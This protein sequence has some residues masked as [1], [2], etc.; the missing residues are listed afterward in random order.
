MRH[1]L[2]IGAGSIGERHIRCFQK[3]GRANVSVCEI[4][5]AL[6]SRIA[7]D[8]D[9]Q[10]TYDDLARALSAKPDGVVIAIP[11]DL[12]IPIALQ[13]AEAGCHLLIEKPLSTGLTGV[14][15]LAQRMRDQ[16]LV[17]QVG[18]ILR[19]YPLAAKVK[20]GIDQ[21]QWGKPLQLT[22]VSGQNFPTCRPAYREIYYAHHEKG[23]G[24]IQDGLTHFLDTAHWWLGPIDRLTGDMGHLSL[25]GVEVEDTV[26]VLARHGNVM[27]LY[28]FNQHQHPNETTFTLVCENATVRLDFCANRLCVMTQPDGDWVVES[29]DTFQRDDA[30]INQADAFLDAIDGHSTISCTLDEAW[31]TL[32]C[33]LAL[34]EEAERASRWQEVNHHN[35]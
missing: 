4:D 12:H 31:H 13:A 35:I 22:V 25:E 16:H 17:V 1:I 20:D 33:Q 8:Y 32:E 14:E 24:A 23:G 28:H 27:G 6:R 7:T 21:G 15:E 30:F 11:A 29:N 3:T 5:P 2:V 19:H 9:L 34:L 10:H 18:Y 26:N